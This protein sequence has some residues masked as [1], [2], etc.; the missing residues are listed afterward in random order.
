MSN[1]SCRAA[2]LAVS[3]FEGVLWRLKRK[4]VSSLSRVKD[5]VLGS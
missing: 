2:R 3:L 4:S 5:W 1:C